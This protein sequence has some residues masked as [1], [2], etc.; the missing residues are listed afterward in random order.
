MDHEFQT[1][2]YISR[3]MMKK[4]NIVKGIIIIFIQSK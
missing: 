3:Y 2:L 1:Y 4:T